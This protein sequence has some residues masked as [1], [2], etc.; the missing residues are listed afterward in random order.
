[1]T[2]HFESRDNFFVNGRACYVVENPE[3]CNDFTHLIGQEV[4]IDNV[5]WRI[6][7]VECFL[8]LP[9]FKVGEPI[10][11]MVEALR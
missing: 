10:A 5:A 2:R 3:R 11:L 8:H 7:G 6:V 1:M 9:P 4:E